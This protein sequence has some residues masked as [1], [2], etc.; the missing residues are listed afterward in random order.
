[1]LEPQDIAHAALWAVDDTPAFH[2]A[3]SIHRSAE[4]GPF[5]PTELAAS[6]QLL[7][8]LRRAMQ[9]RLLLERSEWQQLLALEAL[10]RLA[11]GALLVDGSGR[12]VFANRAALELAATRDVIVVEARGIRTRHRTQ[13]R[14]L[15]SLIGSAI[16]GGPGGALAVARASGALPIAV[17][18]APLKGALALAAAVDGL[19]GAAAIFLSDPERQVEPSAERLMALYGFTPTEARVA[20]QVAR[21]GT[22]AGAAAALRLAPETVRTHL[23]RIYTK[24]GINRQSALVRLLASA[25]ALRLP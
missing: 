1:M 16:R 10:D 14:L 2:V 9:L 12:V 8:H 23:K 19:A 13:T 3:M 11:S 24:T 25:A 18:V 7:P 6:Q 17:L 21:A 22:I 4:R 15:Q 20:I 5:T